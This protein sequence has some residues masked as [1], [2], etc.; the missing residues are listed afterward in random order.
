MN[1]EKAKFELLCTRSSPYARKILLQIHELELMERVKITHCH[2][3]E[4]D[5]DLRKQNPLGKIPVLLIDVEPLWDSTLITRALDSLVGNSKRMLPC[6]SGEMWNALRIQTIGDGI[7]DAA[8]ELRV[9]G[10]RFP[11]FKGD[12]WSERKWSSI[13]S[14]LRW[15]DSR[16]DQSVHIGHLSVASSL[17]Y[18]EF[19]HPGLSWR[20]VAPK[21]SHWFG[22]YSMRP[23][24]MDT[25]FRE[26]S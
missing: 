17:A 26:E 13:Y 15:L 24:M 11:D 23:S 5:E 9:Q 25:E 10:L 22:N 16:V 4:M 12:W 3:F 20:T 14:A 21:L 18:L 7:M 1:I 8:V 6:D 19:R 2:P